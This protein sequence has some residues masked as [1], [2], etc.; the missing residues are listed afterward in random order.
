MFPE[1][2][3]FEMI[4]YAVSIGLYQRLPCQMT[5]AAHHPLLLDPTS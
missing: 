1:L 5:S 2:R 4:K 3:Q